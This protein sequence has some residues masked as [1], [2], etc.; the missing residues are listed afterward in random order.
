[1]LAG[2]LTSPP[3]TSAELLPPDLAA[4]LDALD[5]R[6]RRLLMGKL[7]GERRSKR[8]GRSVEFDDYRQYAPGDD[9]RHIDWNA[10]ARLDRLFIKLFQEEEDL[11]L[12]IVLDAS[13]SM[14]AGSGRANKLLFAARLAA[15]VAYLGL[16]H[17]NRVSLAVL[18]PRGVRLCQPLRGKRNT[19]RLLRWLLDSAFEG[20]GATP[21]LP[22]SP[23]PT[24][25]PTATPAR[26][27]QPPLAQT[28]PSAPE[29]FSDALTRL[30]RATRGRG[31]VAVI[32][33][34]LVPPL[35]PPGY[36][37]G[38]AAL[39]HAGGDPTGQD[40]YVLHT[41]CP[42]ELDPGRPAPS[43]APGDP[44]HPAAAPATPQ[45]SGDLR[46]LDCEL[47][48]AT[49]ITVTPELLRRYQM[50]V[51]EFVARAGSWC[52]AR[53]IAHTLIRT[54]ASLAEVA[55]RSLVRLGM[56]A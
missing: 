10:L 26:A 41:L 51:Q 38:L 37:A 6:T 28:S 46:L 2:A 12:Q 32:S 44:A 1:M 45:L 55:L 52:R 25:T 43:P 47:G 54:D 3:A 15:A 53:D 5:V 8:R 49:E 50:R 31:V 36:A 48:R 23:T 56:L 4:S 18:S 9:P 40:V 17:N 39:R 34:L 14:N 22:P 30:A 7:Q 11:S 24:A 20:I 27:P 19:E 35:D 42:E 29:G 16:A 33:D 21:Q 13:P